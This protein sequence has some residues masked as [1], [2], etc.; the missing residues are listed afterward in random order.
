MKKPKKNQLKKP[1]TRMKQKKIKLLIHHQ[2]I[3]S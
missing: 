3:M 1:Q 2:T